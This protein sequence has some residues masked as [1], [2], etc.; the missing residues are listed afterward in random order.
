MSQQV[1]EALRR[2][3]PNADLNLFLHLYHF[4]H[5]VDIALWSYGEIRKDEYLREKAL[6]K[7]AL[8][9]I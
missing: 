7:D 2:I 9:G 1:Y 6:L 4:W 5:D 3:F 8:E